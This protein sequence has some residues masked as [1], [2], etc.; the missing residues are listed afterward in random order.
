MCKYVI[1]V[2]VV[3]VRDMVALIIPWR[4]FG[5]QKKKLFFY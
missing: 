3:S 4:V 1:C 2:E 5:L